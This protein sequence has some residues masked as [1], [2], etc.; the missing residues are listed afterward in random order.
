[1]SSLKRDWT[2]RKLNINTLNTNAV[3]TPNYPYSPDLDPSTTLAT[4]NAGAGAG[5]GGFPKCTLSNATTKA[6]TCD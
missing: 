1:M 3:A 2:S 4:V 6:Y 5:K